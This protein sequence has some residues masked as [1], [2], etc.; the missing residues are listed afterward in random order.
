MKLSK[1]I[2]KKR[3]KLAE[4]HMREYFKRND[5]PG[6]GSKHN[7]IYSAGFDAGFKE[8][9]EIALAGFEVTQQILEETGNCCPR[10][11]T[12]IIEELKDAVTE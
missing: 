8:A 10:A 6:P 11:I 7:Q 4:E 1:E 2:I 9:S 12:E 3:E 5:L